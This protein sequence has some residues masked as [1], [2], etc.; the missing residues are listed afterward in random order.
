M[1]RVS[2]YVCAS[3][4]FGLAATGYWLAGIPGIPLILAVFGLTWII[5]QWRQWTWYNSLAMIVLGLS[6]GYGAWLRFSPILLIISMICML[7]TWNLSNFCEFLEKACPEDNISLIERRYLTNVG[8]FFILAILI[9]LGA[10]TINFKTS[11]IQ[12]VLLVTIG[13]IGVLQLVRWL[14]KEKQ[15]P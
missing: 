11:F 6:D 10:L 1:S 7:L 15:N 2:L 13:T 4:S 9:S 5:A 8:G 12:A 14:V 3:I